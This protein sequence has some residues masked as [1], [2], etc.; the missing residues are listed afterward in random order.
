MR[1]GLNLVAAGFALT[2]LSYGLAR[3]AFGL[4]LPRIRD[5]L[6]LGLTAAGWIGGSAFLAYC[7]GIIV[8]FNGIGRVGARFIALSAGLSA[9]VGMGLV[10]VASTQWTLGLGIAL[11]GLSTGLASPPLATAVAARFGDR[12]S[13]KAN[14]TINAGTAAGIVLAG[15]AALLDVG[16]WREVYGVFSLFGVGVTVWLWYAVPPGYTASEHGQRAGANLRRPGV[17]ALCASAFLMGLASTANW[18]FGADI[19]RSEFEFSSDRLA[20]VWLVVGAAGM[21]G[22]LTGMLTNRFGTARIHAL[23]LLAIA[24]GTL[25]LTATAFSPAYGFVA[26]GVFGA[27]YIVSSGALLIRGIELFSDRP[28]LG[29]GIPFLSLAIGQSVGTPLFGATLKSTG[30]TAA[31]GL[32]AAAACLAIFIR[33]GVASAPD[34]QEAVGRSPTP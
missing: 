2:A 32:F 34:V 7:V 22:S 5:D 13:A 23:S 18:T 31:L 4:L 6:S 14:A 15:M 24:C 1:R 27:A 33:P 11:A 3:F 21:S 9:S 16:S 20:W 17:F 8:A 28:E 19:L 29:L 10:S 26:M 25:G 12:D 30:S